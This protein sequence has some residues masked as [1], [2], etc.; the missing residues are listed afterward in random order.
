MFCAMQHFIFFFLQIAEQEMKQMPTGRMIFVEN[1]FN[2]WGRSPVLGFL[3][4]IKAFKAEIIAFQEEFYRN[5]KIVKRTTGRMKYLWKEN[6][7]Y[8]VWELEKSILLSILYYY[9]VI[10]VY[11]IVWNTLFFSLC[12]TTSRQIRGQ[13]P[14]RSLICG[15][16]PDYKSGARVV[17]ESHT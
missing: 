10:L 14:E 13:E 11:D 1:I 9:I 7:V 15:L 4:K 2:N 5:I 8:A 16:M 12:T 17:P 6:Q 3:S